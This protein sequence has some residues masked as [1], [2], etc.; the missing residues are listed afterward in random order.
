VS[1][2]ASQSTSLGTPKHWFPCSTL[3]VY[4]KIFQSM[5]W[6]KTNVCRDDK[7]LAFYKILRLILPKNDLS[8]PMVLVCEHENVSMWPLSMHISRYPTTIEG[9]YNINTYN[10]GIYGIVILQSWKDSI[11]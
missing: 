9:A 4:V 1:K 7:D 5:T 3:H 2:I 8:Y 10:I 11:I 6:I